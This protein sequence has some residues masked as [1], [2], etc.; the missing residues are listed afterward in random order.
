MKIEQRITTK[1]SSFYCGWG[2]LEFEDPAGNK[3]SITV[4]VHIVEVHLVQ[5]FERQK[6]LGN[7]GKGL[8]FWSEQG[9]ETSH[10]DFAHL[11]DD[12]KYVRDMSHHQYDSQLKKCGVTYNSRHTAPPK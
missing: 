3:I 6:A 5:F 1:F 8:G 10:S 11:W 12:G 2:S 9:V 4:K 7:G